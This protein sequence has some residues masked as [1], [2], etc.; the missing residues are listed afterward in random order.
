M[1]CVRCCVVCDLF[2]ERVRAIPKKQRYEKERKGKRE[3]A[4]DK[5]DERD[6]GT[7]RDVNVEKRW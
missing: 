6:L 5:I 3:Y 4:S 7:G 1:V 2:K